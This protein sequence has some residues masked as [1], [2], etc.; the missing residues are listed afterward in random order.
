MKPLPDGAG[1]VQPVT[2]D[3]REA[4]RLFLTWVAESLSIGGAN[5]NKAETAKGL[6]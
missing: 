3:E 5:A 2:E 1:I 6:C 4:T